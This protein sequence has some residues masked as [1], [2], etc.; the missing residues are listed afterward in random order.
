MSPFLYNKKITI[1][2]DTIRARRDFKEDLKERYKFYLNLRYIALA[3]NKTLRKEEKRITREL[4][5]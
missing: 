2:R 3:K 1:R 4:Y 5:N